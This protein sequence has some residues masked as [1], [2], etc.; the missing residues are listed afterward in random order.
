M[1]QCLIPL[2]VRGQEL[3]ITVDSAEYSIDD[4]NETLRALHLLNRRPSPR[5]LSDSGVRPG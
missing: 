1:L 3:N 2:A 4:L 5:P